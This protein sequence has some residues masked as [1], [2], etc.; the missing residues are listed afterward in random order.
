MRNVKKIFYSFLC[1]L[2][3]L[4]LGIPLLYNNDRLKA[5]EYTGEKFIDFD[6][7][8]TR[9]GISNNGQGAIYLITEDHMVMYKPSSIFDGGNLLLM[10]DENERPL[11]NVIKV[12]GSGTTVDRNHNGIAL[13]DD[14]KI[15]VWGDN[16]YGQFGNGITSSTY[17]DKAVMVD[18]GISDIISVVAGHKTN[19]LITANGDVYASGDNTDGQF[20]NGTNTGSLTFTKLN[21]DNVKKLT[22]AYPDTIFAL[23][24]DGTVYNW[25]V[26]AS[27]GIEFKSNVNVPVQVYAENKSDYLTN[28]IDIDANGMYYYVHTRSIGLGMLVRNNDM[29]EYYILSSKDRGATSVAKTA[30]VEFT[31]E[32]SSFDTYFSDPSIVYF[33]NDGKIYST[34]KTDTWTE[35][36]EQ[37]INNP[38]YSPIEQPYRVKKIQTS[39]NSNKVAIFEDGRLIIDGHIISGMLPLKITAEK[40]DQTDYSSGELYNQDVKLTAT[41]PANQNLT[42]QVQDPVGSPN[43]TCSDFTNNQILISANENRVYRKYIFTTQGMTSEFIVDI[44]KNKPVLGNY[45]PSEVNEIGTSDRIAITAPDAQKDWN[46]YSATITDSSGKTSAYAGATLALGSYTLTVTDSYGN[47]RDYEFEVSDS[48]KPTADFNPANTALTYGDNPTKVNQTIGAF[49][50]QYPTGKPTSTIKTIQLGTAGDE[51]HFSIDTSGNLKVKGNDLDAGTYSVTVSGTD[52]ND[53]AFTKTVSITVDKKDQNYQITNSAN[54]SLQV[55]QEIAITTSGNESG[56]SETYSI[57]NGNTVAQIS[58]GNKFKILDSGTFTLE[59]TVAGNTNYNSKTVTKQITISQLPTQ[60]PPVSITSKDSMMYGD[61]YTPSYSGGQGS[62]A[63]SWKIE[64]DNGTGAVLNNGS[65]KVTGIGSFTLKVTKAGTSS[66]QESSATKVIT[67]NKRKTTVKPKD[68]TKVVGEAFKPNGATYNPQPISGDNLGTLTITSKYPYN[69]VPG[70]YT[71]GIQASGLSNPN[72][73]FVYQE[74]TL[75]VNSNALPN[76]GEGYYKVTGTKGKN[77]WYISDVQISTTNKNGY[78]EI[79]KDGINFQT[80]ALVY[81]SDGSYPTDFYLRNSSTGIISKAIRYQLKIDQTAPDVP[82]VTMK[83]VNKNIVARFINALSFGNWMN[84]AVQVTMTSSDGTSGID[85]YEYTETSQNKPSTKT[86]TNG[87]VTYQDDVEL[88]VK[89]KACDK[90]GNCSELSND[91]SVMIDTKAPTISGVKDKS[92]YKQYY[93]PRYVNVKDNGS[94]L[95]Y[96]EYKKDGVNEGTIQNNV[97]E[98]ITGIGEYEVY[99]I[100]NAGNEITITFKIVSLPDIETEIDGSDESKEIIDQII[101]ELEEIKDK[102]DET[103]KKDIEDWIEDALEKWESLR[104]KVVE[105]DDKSAKVEGQGDTDFDPS[106]V[107]I[108]DDITD[109]AED[110]PPL[111]RKAINVYDVYLQ[112]GNVR[113]QPDGSIKVYLPYTEA[114]AKTRAVEETKPIVY[115]IDEQDKVKEINS[116]KEGNFVTFITDE[117][118]RYAIS[119]DKQEIN[120]DNNCVVGPDGKPNTGDEVCGLPSEDGKQPEKK[121]DGSV[122]VPDGGKVEFPNGTEIDTPDGAIIKPDGTVVLPDGTE[123]DPNGNKKPGD[124]CVVG[125]DGKPSTGDEVCGKPNEDGKQPEKKPDGS[126][127]IPDGGK[128]EF[129]NGTEIDTPDGAIIKPDG[130]VVLPD[131]TEY[132]PN[133]NKKPSKQCKLDGTKLN[134]DTNGDGIPDINIDLDNDCV[135]DLNVDMNGDNIPDIDIDSDGDGKPDINIDKDGDGK[136]DLNILEIKSWK[137]DKTVTVNGFTYN[138]MSG[139]KP[140]LNIDADGDGEADYNIDTNGDGIPDKN[141]LDDSY[142]GADLNKNLGGANTGDNTKWA[143]WWILLIITSV[144]MI[145]AQYKKRKSSRSNH[146]DT[147]Q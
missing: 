31:E 75:I 1:I 23:K 19:F 72:Y 5:A 43:Q 136:A 35:S 97:D 16:S 58:N 114:S 82:T 119:N 47:T 144:T 10:Y 44:Y 55:N 112:K 107:L 15:Y 100:D 65:V 2:L 8:T 4:S 62:G 115:E 3:F 6:H 108:V 48:P 137:P 142:N 28:V 25:G 73:D 140:Y 37:V 38:D 63:V 118:L 105:T 145:Y 32:V 52:G 123:Y 70:R 132:D 34:N 139:L 27:D 94:G 11:S 85:Y 103:E 131:G 78:D 13:R 76:N 14:G 89:A 127:E 125:P 116:K 134:V 20:G 147:F 143:W 99:A 45:S 42:C 80:T 56:G 101:D 39:T 61:T 53:M 86:S 128:V 41:V 98:K 33:I 46:N 40:A 141:L 93:L 22:Y 54:Y 18:T 84:Q 69:Q 109:Q 117:L 146:K 95:S 36:T 113:I 59:A 81:S 104:K 110:I 68:V 29:L 111:P 64:S 92:E 21:I 106:V 121:P 17:T 102:I 122:E 133:G 79:S 26:A 87:I 135:A 7:F 30:S 124:T 60:N 67:V 77:N 12:S 83:E 24:N 96:S 71:D 126:V 129:P 138:T 66:Y 57:T 50:L 130:T 74:G 90:A 91:E 120:K 49:S 51:D 9:E 88:T